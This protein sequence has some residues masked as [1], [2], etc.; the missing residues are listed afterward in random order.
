MASLPPFLRTLLV[1]DGTVTKSLEAFFWEPV[2]VETIEQTLLKLD[3]ALP[4]LDCNAGDTV[5][6]R[7]VH[8]RGE[9]SQRIF[10]YANSYLVVDD[11]PTEVSDAL[12]ADKIGIGELLREMGLETYREILDLGHS[13]SEMT[14]LE[15]P[16]NCIYRTYV[17]QLNTRPSIQI[18][19]YFPLHIYEQYEK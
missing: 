16:K 6:V 1:A 11:L 2:Q 7:N 4:N 14:E 9:K 12:L 10:A 3:R 18:T 17:I 15:Q 19:E 5:L 13:N 8:L